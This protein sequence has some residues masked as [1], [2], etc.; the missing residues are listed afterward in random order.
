MATP[1]CSPG[2]CVQAGARFVA[3]RSPFQGADG[4]G[5]CQRSSPTGGAAYGILWNFRTPSTVEPRTAPPSVG[6]TFASESAARALSALLGASASQ[7]AVAVSSPINAAPPPGFHSSLPSQSENRTPAALLKPLG[8]LRS[9]RRRRIRFRSTAD[10]RSAEEPET[11]AVAVA[12]K[13]GHRDKCSAKNVST[14]F[15]TAGTES[16]GSI[17]PTSF[18]RSS[19]LISPASW[20]CGAML[21]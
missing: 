14:W 17:A 2:C 12:A 5:S 20:S 21:L 16:A 9:S 13:D 6:T 7:Q 10:G 1:D 8:K 3:S 19:A 4:C 18:A 15:R 11:K